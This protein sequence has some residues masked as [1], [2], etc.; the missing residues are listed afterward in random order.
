MFW[1][2]ALVLSLFGADPAAAQGCGPQNPN[3][4]V[5]TAPFG[6]SNNQAASTEFVNTATGGG[7]L[8]T[9]DF[10]LMG[11]GAS[12]ATFKG[13]LQSGTGAVT[14]TWQSKTADLPSLKDF[15]AVCDGV[16]NDATA[17]SNATGAFSSVLLTGAASSTGTKCKV[18]TAANALTG[19]LFGWNTQLV[20]GSSNQ[21]GYFFS[22]VSANQAYT[23]TNENSVETAF[24]GN[25]TGGQFVVEHRITGAATLTQP[26]TGYVYSPWA[27]PHYTFLYNE[28]GFNNGTADNNG[29]TAAVAYRSKVYNAGQGDAVAF[30]ASTFVTGT[31]AGST[32]FLANPAVTMFN[33]DGFA[34][35]DG[36]YINA[37]ELSLNDN[38][39]DAAGIGWVINLN[40]T[41]STG[42]KGAYWAGF[43]AH[44]HGS[45]SGNGA[46]IGLGK[47]TVGLDF[48]PLTTDASK[49]AIAL[50]AND[51]IYWNAS[52]G[53]GSFMSSLG[54]IWTTY[55]SGNT[56]LE[57]VLNNSSPTL[58]LAATGTNVNFVKITAVATGNSPAVEAVGGD[59]NIQFMFASKGA[60][61]IIFRTQGTAGATQFQ[62][63]DTVGATRNISVTGSNGG[64]PT[65]STTA[66]GLNV[67]TNNG[68][69]TYTG[70]A[71]TLT[72]GCNGAGQ[73]ISGSDTAGTITGQTAASTSCTLTFATAYGAAPNCVASG[74]TA[75]LT[76]AITV[77]TGTLVVN[78]PSTAN[79]KWSYICFGS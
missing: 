54:N 8:G 33:G 46:F 78:F 48:T 43:A 12:P 16:T 14:R 23:A 74:Q 18:S 47:F 1:I 52:A 2:L 40:R 79:F 44:S 9:L 5:P 76:G 21:R 3:C 39:F 61:P 60:S 58:Q 26:T 65:L 51:R 36:V 35:A 59:A 63:S 64:N 24:N 56:A 11:N 27:Y 75:P 32:S 30:N 37:G 25:F 17:V 68:H 62:I 73:V 45:A 42:A 72:A 71:P 50:V 53:G 28:S 38:G 6:T 49:A 55:N 15:G 41:I 34:G 77:G 67:A 70:T 7:G 66:G 20:D 57:F 19:K 10:A 4:I 31:R 69:T 29:R 22:S 13:F